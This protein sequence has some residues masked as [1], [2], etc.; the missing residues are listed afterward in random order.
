MKFEMKRVLKPNKL[1]KQDLVEIRDKRKRDGKQEV[2]SI[3]KIKNAIRKIKGIEDN[4]RGN[5]RDSIKEL[6][7]YIAIESN[8]GWH[9]EKSPYVIPKIKKKITLCG[10]FV[11]SITRYIVLDSKKHIKI[12]SNG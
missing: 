10:V 1:E 4:I 9:T 11:Q 8:L 7:I 6:K 2:F 3:D 12:Y 5:I